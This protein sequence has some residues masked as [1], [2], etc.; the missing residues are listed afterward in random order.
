MRASPGQPIAFV[1][2]AAHYLGNECLIWPFGSGADYGTYRTDGKKFGKKVFAH[3]AVCERVHG[4]APGEKAQVAHSC[5]RRACVNPQHLRWATNG[6]NQMDRVRHGTSNRGA[7]HGLARLTAEQVHAIR[8][9]DLKH[10]Q[11]AKLYGV[12]RSHITTIRSGRAWSWL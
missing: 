11:L 4:P 3:R 1:E 6:E 8:A 7:S 12:S 2:T 5:G 10:F 9:S